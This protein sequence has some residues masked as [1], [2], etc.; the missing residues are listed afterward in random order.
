MFISSI[1]QVI[2]EDLSF[3]PND[4]PVSPRTR[5]CKQIFE[6]FKYFRYKQR[7]FCL[8]EIVLCNGSRI[9]ILVMAFIRLLRPF[10][11]T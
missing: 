1:V 4:L 6:M 7:P 3:Y 11:N 2:F 5:Q 8:W 10:C 9:L